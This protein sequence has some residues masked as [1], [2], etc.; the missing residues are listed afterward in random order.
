MVCHH[1]AAKKRPPG[2]DFQISF[3]TRHLYRGIKSI[4]MFEAEVSWNNSRIIHR[5]RTCAYI[6]F[7][8]QSKFYMSQ[9]LFAQMAI[10]GFSK[11]G[12]L[13]E[14]VKQYIAK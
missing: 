9:L 14:P 4:H 10:Q 1:K 13:K 12:S 7:L 2:R 8:I 3:V 11:F 6:D 5:A